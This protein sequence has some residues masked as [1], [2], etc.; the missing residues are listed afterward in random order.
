MA[1]QEDID[2]LTNRIAKAESDRDTWRAAGSN[3]KYLGA[4]FLV[5]N[6]NLQLYE[7]LRQFN[8]R[9]QV[10]SLHGRN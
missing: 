7:L 9:P 8:C 3:E 2:A 5:E 10:A 4:Y 6:L 1:I